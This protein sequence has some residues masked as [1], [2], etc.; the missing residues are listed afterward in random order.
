MTLNAQ[1]THIHTGR[2]EVGNLKEI[3]IRQTSCNESGHGVRSTNS[4]LQFMCHLTDEQQRLI[5]SPILHCG[6]AQLEEFTTGIRQTISNELPLLVQQ[7]VHCSQVIRTVILETWCDITHVRS[8]LSRAHIHYLIYRASIA[9]DRRWEFDIIDDDLTGTYR[10]IASFISS[11]KLQ[12]RGPYREHITTG[13]PRIIGLCYFYAQAAV[14]FSQ[15]Q[16]KVGKVA[17]F[18]RQA[19][20]HYIGCGAVDEDRRCHIT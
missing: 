4:R 6:S 12:D 14:I 19:G 8:T 5:L 20:Q 16:A 18:S 1:A 10:G 15:R 9:I 7:T 2:A 11:R 13:E 3:A 17:A